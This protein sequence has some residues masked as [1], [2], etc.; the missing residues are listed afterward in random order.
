MCK[1]EKLLNDNKFSDVI[2]NVGGEKIHAHKNILAIKSAVFATMFEHDM[3]EKEQ[4]VVEIKDISSN[5]LKEMLRYIYVGR[6]NNIIEIASDLLV[7]A[8]KYLLANLKNMCQ[9][10]L[11]DNLSHSNVI[12]YLNLAETNNARIL[13]TRVIIYI[14]SNLINVINDPE[15]QAYGELHSS[16]MCEIFQKLVIE[17]EDKKAK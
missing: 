14:G 9:E 2:L 12:K 1:Y 7:A 5:V 16:L 6:V 3:A 17:R 11:C 8:D 15:F 10:T 4:N 13:K